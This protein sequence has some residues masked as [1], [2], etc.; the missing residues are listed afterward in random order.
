[1]EKLNNMDKDKIIKI[2]ESVKDSPNKDLIESRDELYSE[3]NKTKQLIIDL[4][5]HLEIVEKYYFWNMEFYLSHTEKYERKT[6][7]AK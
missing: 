5:R 2:V 3:Y 6:H 1:M 4:T 7:C